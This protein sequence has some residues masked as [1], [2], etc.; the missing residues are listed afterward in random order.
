MEYKKQ[1][2]NNFNIHYI[3]TDRFK[4]INIEIFFT[5]E[6]NSKDIALSNLLCDI[7]NYTTKSYNT[8]NKCS[9]KKEEL[10]SLKSYSKFGI[11]G[12]SDFIN[13]TME[14]LHPKY[15]EES[16]LEESLKFLKEVLFNPN[17]NNNSFDD[18]TFEILKSNLISKIKA[19]NDDP[20]ILSE[21]NFRKVM[22]EN[23][24][25]SY[26]SLGQKEEY[27]KI[28]SKDSYSFYLN[29]FKN[30][31]IDVIVL[32]ELN[33]QYENYITDYIIKMF[34]N[35]KPVHKEKISL[36]INNKDIS[37]P[38]QVRQKA[39]FNQ[40]QL[41]MGYRF[42][43][44]SDYELKF[45]FSLYNIMLGNLPNAILF[46]KLRSKNSLCYGVSSSRNIYNPSLIIS[47]GINKVNAD[48]AIKLI[49]DC[50][51]DMTRLSKITPLF[52]VSLKTVNTILNDY[53][54]DSRSII[55]YY[56]NSEFESIDD[57]E[58]RRQK[59]MEVKPEEITALAK[60]VHLS[61]TYLLEGEAEE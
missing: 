20:S 12:A 32:G 44:V 45:V 61:A 52:K 39:D 30:Y 59:L 48:K 47:S 35:V 15:T 8:K 19:L 26:S 1:E 51:K 57:I 33:P 21:L 60:K 50:V 40:S 14:F 9:I 55:D 37:K 24:P 18:K 23:T 31:K 17:V 6:F 7:M 27:E 16:M 43:D 29:L 56:Y 41:I 5:K 3:N 25:T 58:I 4:A 10:Y 46:S 49:T 11:N 28:N 13:F 34:K 54:D 53:Y 38:K 36:V 42:K 22:Y 2:F